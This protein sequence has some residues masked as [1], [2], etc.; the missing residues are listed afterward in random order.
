MEDKKRQESLNIFEKTLTAQEEA[1]KK[2]FSYLK[3]FFT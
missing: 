1:D 3:N 2:R